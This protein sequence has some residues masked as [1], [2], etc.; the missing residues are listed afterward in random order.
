MIRYRDFPPA[1]EATDDG[2]GLGPFRSAVA[3]ANAWLAAEGVEALNVET[4]VLPNA[5]ASGEQGAE[6]TCLRVEGGADWYQ[7]VRV[8]F[9]EG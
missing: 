3:A 8:W 4:V 5:L 2:F 7:F 9:R 6:D 1:L